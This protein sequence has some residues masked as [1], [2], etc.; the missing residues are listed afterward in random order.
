MRT[1]WIPTLFLPGPVD[2]HPDVLAAASHPMIGHRTPEAAALLNELDLGLR[3]WLGVETPVYAL[4]CSATLAMEACVRNLVR[5]KLL[6]VNAGVFAD[7]WRITAQACGREVVSLDAPLA[8]GATP[9]ALDEALRTHDV[10]AVALVHVETGT[11]VAAPMRE[12]LDVCARHPNVFVMM[13]AVTSVGA[14]PVLGSRCDAVF[15]ASQ[16]ALG[17][18]PG[19]TFLA[20]SA[21]AIAVSKSM[22]GR[23]LYTDFS[24]IDRFHSQGGSPFT[25][26]LPVFFAAIA[27]VR[28]LTTEGLAARF[29]LHVAKRDRWLTLASTLFPHC[30]VFAPP[31]VSVA[32]HTL[33]PTQKPADLIDALRAKTGITLAPGIG[34]LESNTFRVGLMGDTTVADIERVANAVGATLAEA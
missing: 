13:D 11:G 6:V 9:E 24:R 17:M 12:L 32:V 33:P 14:M 1:A 15:T 28:R 7:R 2:V 10:E 3:P 34:A 23:G 16:K 21:R 25:P 22:E 19:L 18:P 29:A 5:K 31:C 4:T 8:T 20:L 26:A 27:Q 30:P